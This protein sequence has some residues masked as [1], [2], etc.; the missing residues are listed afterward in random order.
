MY[1]FLSLY[2]DVFT[3]YL[4]FNAHKR[5]QVTGFLQQF[6]AFLNDQNRFQV[7]KCLRLPFRSVGLAVDF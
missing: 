2:P 6:V 7:V 4:L 5:N 3:T 1:A